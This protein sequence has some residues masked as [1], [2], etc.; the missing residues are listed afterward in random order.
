[1]IKTDP[2]KCAILLDSTRCYNTT[3]VPDKLQEM[4]IHKIQ[5]PPRMTNLL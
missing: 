4:K 1:M 3:V 2:E 5:I